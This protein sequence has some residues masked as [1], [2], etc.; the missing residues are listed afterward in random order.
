M[1]VYVLCIANGDNTY[2]HCSYT[3]YTIGTCVLPQ[4]TAKKKS[5]VTPGMR[6]MCCRNLFDA[7][8]KDY[9][10]LSYIHYEFTL[11]STPTVT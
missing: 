1:C 2:V 8:C 6:I 5:S 11:H 10:L 9:N 7:H 3:V 4:F